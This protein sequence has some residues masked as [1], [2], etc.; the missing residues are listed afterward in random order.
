MLDYIKQVYWD[1][2]SKFDRKCVMKNFATQVHG[3]HFGLGLWYTLGVITCTA[4]GWQQQWEAAA[5]GHS[6]ACPHADGPRLG[7]LWGRSN[8]NGAGTFLVCYK[9]HL[10]WAQAAVQT[11][12]LGPELLSPPPIPHFVWTWASLPF[13]EEVKSLLAKDV[14]NNGMGFYSKVAWV[15]VQAQKVLKV[16]VAISPG[17]CLKRQFLKKLLKN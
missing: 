5:A 1:R 10:R 9:Y 2:G 4:E 6:V 15:F 11:G 16:T 17:N 8:T 13:I 3:A 12:A 14:F 7:P